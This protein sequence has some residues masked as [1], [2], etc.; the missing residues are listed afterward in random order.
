MCIYWFEPM[1]NSLLSPIKFI[2]Y[3]CE[4]KTWFQIIMC[5][6]SVYSLDRTFIYSLQI[7]EFVIVLI[8]LVSPPVH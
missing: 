1:V 2:L 7:V 5:R 6:Y 3:I 4:A 8:I